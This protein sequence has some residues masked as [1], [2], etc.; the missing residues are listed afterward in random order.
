MQIEL[1]LL[2][3]VIM[4]IVYFMN[5]MGEKRM[6]CYLIPAIVVW[7]LFYYSGVHS[8]ISGGHGD[9]YPDGAPLQQG[10]L[11]AQD[12]LAEDGDAAGR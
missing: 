2:A 4:M 7:G 3:L 6:I 11:H 1:L 5:K 9:A 10:V 8:T 12:G